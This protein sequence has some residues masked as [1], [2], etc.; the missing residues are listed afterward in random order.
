[1]LTLL[2][3]CCVLA[4][5]GTFAQTLQATTVEN[6]TPE[7]SYQLNPDDKRQTWEGWGVSLCWWA[8]MT[9]KWNDE[10]KIDEIVDWL[11]S[12]DKLNFNLFR[13]NIGGGDDP[14]HAHCAPH[15]MDHGKGHRAEMEGFKDNT[16][17]SYHWERD[18]AQRKIMLKIKERRPDAVFEAFSNSAP[19]YMTYSGCCS[20]HADAGKDNLRPEYYE[21]FAHY[22]VDV[23]RHY[24]DE[25]GIEFRTLDPFNE[26]LTSYWGAG[27]GQEGCHFDLASQVALLKVLNPIL[28]ESGLSTV[29]SASDETSVANAV[30]TFKYYKEQDALSLIG[31]FNTHS[32]TADD[33]SRAQLAALAGSTGMP[34]WMSEVGGGSGTGLAANLN[35]AQKVMD[36][37]RYLQPSAWI[38]WQYMEEG[39]DRWCL[40]K[41]S[42]ADETYERIKAFYVRQQFSQFIKQGYT[43]L[44]TTSGQTLAARSAD[45]GTYVLVM[46]NEGSMTSN[47]DIDLSFF[48]NLTAS[49]IKAWR[50]SST[51]DL[52]ETSDFT[53][54]DGHLLCPL[55]A[56]SI[57]T[58]VITATPKAEA[59]NA[60]EAGATYVVASRA[61]TGCAVDATAL[62]GEEGT[63]SIESYE[64]KA[65]Q[66]W[67][68]EASGEGFR[69]INGEGAILTGTSAYFLQAHTDSRDG[70]TFDIV[71]VDAPYYKIQANGSTRTFDLQNEST[72][73][74][75]RVG[76]WEYGTD[77]SATH[78][79]WA[80]VRLP[81][82][83]NPSSIQSATSRQAQGL[84]TILST[85]EGTLHVALAEELTGT[86]AVSDASGRTVWQGCPSQSTLSLP[87][88]S[89][90]Y[91]VAYKSAKGQCA[92]V[93]LVK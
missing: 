59:T 20:G 49:D 71:A 50:T 60:I 46:L 40:I 23:C 61:A 52:A 62:E 89:G 76:L 69:L 19:Y 83:V 31:Q 44:N 12:S 33:R 1:M 79:Q 91:V 39:N 45:G 63:V 47:H 92:K 25:Y 30:K 42:F 27:G 64:G 29:I 54:A 53:L 67:T 51:E 6:A 93:V 13:Y 22:L 84:M 15:H 18:A 73:S 34:L 17:D 77:A 9:G 68:L 4:L 80:F 85:Q 32:Y 5:M 87:L 11:T 82:D 65:S 26:P 58:L 57:T 8:N 41:G 14:L 55:P 78:R 70:Q 66:Q 16:A 88:K 38:D 3:T 56:A 28:K 74:G 2:R 72:T 21:E 7:L 24:K 36:D 86:L 10:R 37:I 81:D 35:L 48:D 43:I 90:L 75:T